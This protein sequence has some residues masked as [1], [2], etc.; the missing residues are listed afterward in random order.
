MTHH[1][2]HRPFRPSPPTA[3]SRI[4][5]A[6]LAALLC[7]L[8]AVPLA[9]D[10][11]FPDFTKEQKEKIAELDPELQKWLHEVQ[12]L[13]TEDELSAF[14]ELEQDYQRKAFVQRFWRTRD[15]YP[16][17]ASNEFRDRW[18]ELLDEVQRRFGSIDTEVAQLVLLN[19][20]PSGI[21]EVDNCSLL[22]ELQIW[23]YEGSRQVQFDFFFV[24]YRYQRNGA[25]R[26]WRAADGIEQIA[27][28][29]TAESDA[30]RS[31]GSSRFFQD[32]ELRCQDGDIIAA[33]IRWVLSQDLEYESLLV[34]MKKTPQGIDP[35]WVATFNSYS[36]EVEE[37]A[38]GLPAELAI[39]Y[40]GRRQ[41]RTLVQGLL[42]VPVSAAAKAELGEARSY[43]FVLNGEVLRGDELF[44]NFRY[45]FDLPAAEVRGEE[46]PMVFERYLRPGDYKLILKLE[47][48]NGQAFY[49]AERDLEVPSVD[50][51]PP[52]PMDDE[53]ARILREANAAITSGDS[54]LEIVEPRE[55]ILTGYVRFDTLSTGEYDKVTF[56]LDGDPVLTKRRPPYTVELDLGKV[57]RARNLSVTGYDAEGQE[58][59]RDEML[60]NA[61]GSRFSIDLVEPRKGRSYTDSLRAE[62]QVQTP[63]GVE[64][65]RVEFFLNE[66]KVAT[67]YQEPWVQPMVAPKDEFLAYVRAVAY[68]PDGNST[69]DLVFIN[70][71]DY[72]EEIDI[73]YVE[74]YAT[75]LDRN[76]RPVSGLTEEDF[77]PVEDGVEQEI[78]RFEVVDNL[79][80][81]AGV[82]LDISGSMEDSLDEAQRAALQFY[83]Q[84][85]QPKDRASL[86]TFNDRPN[87]VVKFTNE[88]KDLAGGL[89][90]LK[91]ERGTALYDSL[92]FALYYFNGIKGQR[93]LLVL[94]DGK[95]ESSKF[96]FEEALDYARR[97]GV[98]VYTIALRDDAAH[99]KLSKIAEE[100]GGRAFFVEE[101]SALAGVYEAIQQELR[102]RYLVA[103]QSNNTTGDEEFRT[104]ELKVKEPGLEAKTLRGYYP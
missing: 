58:V 57:P 3:G 50:G 28:L 36:T 91:A 74:L 94:S 99:K 70:A 42:S 46:I 53:T 26:L 8:P 51:A 38:K 67:L 40:P 85:V 25:W 97:A 86:M 84:I 78:A 72:Q 37:G 30:R 54:T 88:V 5:L 82:L 24:F 16:D 23:F 2:P 9:A 59:A 22:Q 93:A 62:A 56:A 90:G 10:A 17:T 75:V 95:D 55:E 19:G 11:A 69:E 13:I 41:S 12:F 15:E 100:T 34:R 45:K 49:R 60:V 44:D 98:T 64:P 80:I 71:P 96:S 65:E 35:E 104:V 103:Y 77:L 21:L 87:L 33:A 1:R 61:G 32:I 47:D 7:A 102:S 39:E 4:L 63:E 48:I 76:N 31:V 81:H 43:N 6:L 89:A 18:Y 92:I 83:E 52:E 79:P 20:E 68:L 66:T 14:L 29:F 73:Q 27:E 101:P